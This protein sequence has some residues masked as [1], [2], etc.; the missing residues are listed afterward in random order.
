M[1]SRISGTACNTCAYTA[2]V[3][4]EIFIALLNE[5]NTTG[6]FAALGGGSV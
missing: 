4:D 2:M 1:S 5:P 6:T 3:L